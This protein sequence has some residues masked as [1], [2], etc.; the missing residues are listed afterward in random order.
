M[1]FFLFI[2]CLCL[3]TAQFLVTGFAGSV[4]AAMKADGTVSAYASFRDIP[5][6]TDDEIAA[7]DK[8]QRKRTS[9]IY[10]MPLSAECFYR[11]DGSV[12]G[13]AALV[14]EWMSRLFGLSITPKVYAWNDMLD[15]LKSRTIDFTGELTD[16]PARRNIYLMTDPIATR[17]IKVMRK[18]NSPD[19]S[20]IAKQHALRFG[21][22]DGSTANALISPFVNEKFV[23]VFVSDYESAYSMLQND[24]LDAFFG[25]GPFE[26]TK[27][28]IREGIISRNFFPLVYSQVA[29][30][31]CN[32]ELW[33]I[34]S[35]L[36]KYLQNG[37]GTVLAG[38]YKQ[39]C[40][41]YL[42][43]KLF[44]RL[45]ESDENYILDKQ[46]NGEAIPVVLE[47]DNY[48]I[49]FYNERAG[50]WQGIALDVL[51]G[52]EYLTGLRFAPTHS[53]GMKGSV[54]QE[55]LE[56]GEAAMSAELIRT[57][58]REDHF[59]WADEPYLL[60]YYAL[61]SRAGQE[62]IGINQVLSSKIGLVTGTAYA[63]TFT[64]WFPGHPDTRQYAGYIAGFDA[65]ERGEVDFLMTSRNLL[66]SATHY[67]ERPGFKA[68]LIF[69]H[70]Y[71]SYF[72]FNKEQLRLRKIVSEAQ[73]LVDTANIADSWM[74]RVFD[75]RGKMARERIPYLI[76]VSAL[77]VSL[78]LL[79]AFMLVRHQKI[80]KNLERVVYQRTKELEE[81]T[82]QARSASQA[83]SEFLANMSHEI[84]TPMN[85]II[86]MT[87]IGKSSHD[88]ERKEYCLTKISEASQHLLGVINDILDMSKIEADKFELST[89]EFAFETMLQRVVNVINFRVAEK[90][91]KLFVAIEKGVPFS[92]ITDPQRLAQVIANLLSNA[93]KFT[94][95]AGSITL[96]ARAMEEKDNVCTLRITVTDSGIGISEEQQ[97]KLFSSFTQADGSISR[98]FG[99]TG[100]GLVISKRIVEMMDGRIWIESE[101]GKGASFIFEIKAPV[102]GVELKELLQ[103]N[104]RWDF[105]HVLAADESAAVLGL[106]KT[107]MDSYGVRCET[108]LN[109]E[110]AVRHME[111][112][113]QDPFDL[114]FV[115][116]CLTKMD[117][118]DL[119]QQLL[120]RSEKKP[121]AVLMTA[122]DWS[123]IEHE[124]RDAGVTQFLQKP[125]FPSSLV[126]CVKACIIPQ[127]A[128]QREDSREKSSNENIFAGKCIL[129]AEDVK[130]NQ[131]IVEGLLEETGL[132]LDFADDGQETVDKFTTNPDR[133]MLI[134]MDVQM[135]N[136]DGCEATRVIRAA[137]VPGAGSIP[138]IAMTANVFREDIEHCRDAGMNGHL[139]K[140]VDA[141]E[142]I[143]TLRKYLL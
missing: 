128:E 49:T 85:A 17:S 45:D 107:L 77:L 8:L 40:Q 131:E 87:T 54:L 43:Y 133:Y 22:L 102:G 124:A 142:I 62:D 127:S 11:E 39:G 59:L 35:V 141:E 106:V 2:L 1:R 138:I 46:R 60:D 7:I 10:A 25:E 32:P 123:S 116:R 75:Y 82:Q 125:L 29:L 104:T 73:A 99:G 96:T 51:R 115:D 13:Y 15:G 84:R 55:T 126:D 47:Y 114:I 20:F 71:G 41:D 120:Q 31:T 81:Q 42:R 69:Q 121:A 134:L 4:R 137:N 101:L 19:F 23:P 74:R 119:I 130:I 140:P 16:T 28:M 66:L 112:N 110:D 136:M 89:T 72:G 26:I 97:K 38:M 34:I 53:A 95:E 80:G 3:L 94:P 70:P 93:V 67:L 18:E 109:A 48:P 111:N 63:M 76:S 103:L 44:S 6:V 122:T 30:S 36:Q 37:A 90:K 65:L 68:N 83:K 78:L 64:E 33:P 52:I 117:G 9:F 91:Q 92:I 5:G 58:S 21:F 100:L 24:E 27:D 98:K 139:G 143:R 135:P 14:S 86:G 118:I 57:R 79:L 12:G 88:I 105:L 61:L 113:A 129:I 56:Q 50:E 108:A 132:E